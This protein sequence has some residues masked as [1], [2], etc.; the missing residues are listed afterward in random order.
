[1]EQTCAEL[2]RRFGIAGRA[3]VQEGHGGLLKVR[4][5]SPDAAAEMYLHGA[6]VVS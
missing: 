4:V 3:H 2:D 5:S 1:M 6:H